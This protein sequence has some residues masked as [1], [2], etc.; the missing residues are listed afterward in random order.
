MRSST[1]C[2]E[3]VRHN[4]LQLWYSLLTGID[5]ARILSRGKATH[6]SKCPVKPMGDATSLSRRLV[7]VKAISVGDLI[8]V[9]ERATSPVPCTS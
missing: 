7:D 3:V 6:H 2:D 9:L 1:A 5:E 4:A 8:I